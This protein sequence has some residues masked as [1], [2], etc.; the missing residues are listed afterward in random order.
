MIVTC[1]CINIR[2]YH[3][4]VISFGVVKLD[5]V[6]FDNCLFGINFQILEFNSYATTKSLT[7]YAT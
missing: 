7:K 1:Y 6:I 3:F 4:C 5:A 2:S